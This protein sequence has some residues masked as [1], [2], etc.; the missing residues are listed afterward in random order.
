MGSKASVE[1][2]PPYCE[3]VHAGRVSVSPHSD[4]LQWHD[5]TSGQVTSRH[6]THLVDNAS[7]TWVIRSELGQIVDLAVNNEPQGVLGVVL[8]HFGAVKNLVRSHCDWS[9][10]SEGD[11]DGWSRESVADL[12]VRKRSQ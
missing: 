5:L 1:S 12:D 9:C 10:I 8:C 3:G 4:R 2:L 11:N 7:A 6:V